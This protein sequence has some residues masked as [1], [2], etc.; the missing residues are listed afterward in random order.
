MQEHSTFPPSPVKASLKDSPKNPLS[1]VDLVLNLIFEIDDTAFEREVKTYLIYLKNFKHYSE[2]T[3]RAYRRWLQT[4]RDFARTHVSIEPTTSMSTAKQY[5][6]SID[7]KHVPSPSTNPIISQAATSSNPKYVATRVGADAAGKFHDNERMLIKKLFRYYI[8]ALRQAHLSAASVIQ[9]KAAVT[10][11]LRYLSRYFNQRTGADEAQFGAASFNPAMWFPMVVHKRSL[12]YFFYK[13]EVREVLRLL[14]ALL[15]TYL[16]ENN[17]PYPTY[18]ETSNSNPHRSQQSQKAI[19]SKVT[20]SLQQSYLT[21]R[22]VFIVR[23]LYLLGCRISELGNLRVRDINASTQFVLLRGKGRKERWI[24]LTSYLTRSLPLYL[25]IR[26]QFLTTIHTRAN[27]TRKQLAPAT[28]A[29]LLNHRGH[30]ITTRGIRNAF[31]KIMNWCSDHTSA[32]VKQRFHAAHPHMLRHSL[33]THLMEAGLDLRLIQD[34]LGHTSLATVERYTHVTKEHLKRKFARFHP[35][36]RK[37]DSPLSEPQ[38]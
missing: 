31:Y 7:P 26:E 20:S 25:K 8:Q 34:W 9:A 15:T 14:E 36:E 12:P 30:P 21:V 13:E 23:A 35:Y 11:W 2:H 5:T 19:S 18:I 27:P 33:A 28:E 17:T 6:F 29:L 10:T 4:L 3:I 24:P 22:N 16:K 1:V 38:I 32:E 37:S